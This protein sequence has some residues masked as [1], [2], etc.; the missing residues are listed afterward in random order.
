M[1]DLFGTNKYR[2]LSNTLR[3]KCWEDVVGQDVL[4]GSCGIIHNIFNQPPYPSIIFW[5]PAGSGKT[6]FARLIQKNLAK[7]SLP[8]YS[9]SAVSASVSDLRKIFNYAKDSGTVCLFVDEIHRFNRAQQ[10]IFLPLIETETLILIGA[11]TENPSF[12]INNALLSRTRVLTLSRLSNEDL[13]KILV[14]AEKEL[15]TK[16]PI[17]NKA[18]QELISASDGDARFLL[19]QIETILS[20]PSPGSP[21]SSRD[22]KKIIQSR[23]AYYD[24]NLDEHYNLSSALHKSL[25]GSDVDASLYYLHRMLNGGED[26]NYIA[27]RLL[28]FSYEDVGL[29]DINASSVA[30]TA[31]QSYERLGSPE[32]EL[33]LVNLTIYLALAPKSNSAYLAEKK[34][35]SYVKNSGSLS[36]PKAIL[37]AP[38]NLMKDLGYG[39][40]YKY[41]HNEANSFSGYDFF[42]DGL[43]KQSFYSPLN[44]GFEKELKRRFLWYEKHRNDKLYP[45]QYLQTS[46]KALE[47]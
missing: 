31:W 2:T 25:R 4:V 24:R 39:K 11:T 29:A 43:P 14:K 20:L 22:L 45:K 21:L 15:N 37:N 23:S 34:A 13:D 35:K 10:D 5:G 26:A 7:K 16:L 38:T 36:P 32:G 42:P 40:D 44:I 12:T 28:R 41:D 27:R 6:S 17:S 47:K 8:C 46:D 1:T 3:P 19:N 30:L 33:A 18:R 9:L